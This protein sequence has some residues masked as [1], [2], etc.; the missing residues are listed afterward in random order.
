MNKSKPKESACP[1]VQSGQEQLKNE[2]G[3]SVTA[4]PQRGKLPF[5]ERELL[6][7]LNSDTVQPELLAAPDEVDIER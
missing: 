7:G 6:E 3:A 4:T 1:L 2:L 5:L